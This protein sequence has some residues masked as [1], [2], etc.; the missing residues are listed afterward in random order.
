MVFLADDTFPY[1]IF[2]TNVLF[3]ELIGNDLDELSLVGLGLDISSYIF[4]EE[5]IIQ[6]QTKEFSFQLELPQQNGSNY[7]LFYKGKEI[8]R[9]GLPDLVDMQHFFQSSSDLIGIGQKDFLTWASNSFRTILG[10]EPEELINTDMCRFFHEDDLEVARNFLKDVVRGVERDQFTARILAKDG[11]YK[12]IHWQVLFKEDKFYAT[13][14]DVSELQLE[15]LEKDQ[16][17]ERYRLG[18]KV[19]QI[20]V[21]EINLSL[22]SVYWSDEVYEIHDVSD[23]SKTF[24]V[25]TA[26]DFYPPEFRPTIQ[27]SLE[28]CIKS[29]NDFEHTVMIRTAKGIEKWVQVIGKATIENGQVARVFG[30]FQD[31]SQEKQLIEELSLF[32]ELFDL[33][34]ESIMIM[35]VSGDIIFSNQEANNKLGVFEK[36]TLSPKI[37]K[38]DQKFKFFD[39]WNLHIKQLEQDRYLRYTSELMH[40][41][42]EKFPVE[43]SCNLIEVQGEIYII[44]FS[45]DITERVLLEKSL[46]DS[47]DFL[48]HLT[49]QVP[50]ALYQFVLDSNGV[51][52]FSYLSPGIKSI[53]DLGDKEIN[54]MNDI[55]MIISKI[56]PED[57]AKVLVSSVA[58]AKKLNP[59][60]CQFRVKQ[61]NG[62]DYIWVMGAAKPESME[63]GDVV[64]YGYLSDISE[65]KE[66]E[67]SLKDA[68]EAAEKAS[69]IKSE[70]LSMISHEL[71]TPLNAISGSVYSLLQDNHTIAQKSA[72]NTINFAVDNL[73]I[74]I[75]DLLDFQKIEAGKLNMELN[76]MRIDEIIHQVVNGLEFHARDSQNVLSLHL[77][78]DVKIQVLGD[79]VRLAQVLNNLVTNALKFTKNGEVDVS[80]KLKGVSG[81]KVKIH[82]EVK[83]TGIG[84]AKENL[85]KIFEDFD[86]V[87]HSFSKKYGGTGLGLSIT[88]K[89][90]KRMDSEI[91]V[92]SEVGVG[93][94]FNFEI[95][96]EK[97]PNSHEMKLGNEPNLDVDFSSLKILMAED[98][99]VNALVLGKIIKKWG[100]Q[101]D[102]VI[103]GKEAYESVKEGGFDVVLMDIQM[104]VM[105]GFEATE[106]IKSVSDV[107]VIA[108]TAAAKLE[109]IEDITKSGF[110]GFV[111]KPIDATELLKKIKEVLMIE[112]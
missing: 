74:M 91:Q 25:E 20:G 96:F 6:Y 110:D 103:N 76:P 89:L 83:D 60:T 4:K 87:H 78:P 17:N 68:R 41:N 108:L 64:W 71:R 72:L 12:S 50:G 99:D 2:Y 95:Q 22:K 66:F 86:Q 29:G 35:D 23:F 94:C 106:K 37:S 45:R 102:R 67:N 105:N 30:T 54:G 3:D 43:V 88:R 61:V 31:V 82:F 111:S 10:Y 65:Q 18:E 92:E 93:T 52:K 14:R 24:N 11:K 13:G 97:A 19:A 90:L 48:L 84:I 1:N 55:G 36:S 59:W 39:D 58:S 73:I 34:P 38:Y 49:E 112:S 51:M 79:K 57:I 26:L 27:K 109:V 28:N 47:S 8:K 9:K 100:F 69:K 44:S 107:P 98:N 81:D 104:P 21:W 33:S 62:E 75:N 40:I 32:K 80:V 42:G 63:S 7:F 53:F 101:Y 15:I 77:D 56:H 16:Q 70:F 85:H 46:Q 5:M